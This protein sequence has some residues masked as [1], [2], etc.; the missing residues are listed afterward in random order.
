MNPDVGNS[1]TGLLPPY[2]PLH[3]LGQPYR[4][5]LLN[6]TVSH[7]QSIPQHLKLMGA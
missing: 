7:P 6:W 3:K 4:K 2:E 1:F 5:S